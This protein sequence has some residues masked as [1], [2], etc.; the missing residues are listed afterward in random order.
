MDA[1][2]VMKIIPPETETIRG[3]GNNQVEFAAAA[4]VRRKW[5]PY[6]THTIA[7]VM[8]VGSLRV[9]Y[10][11]RSRIP[12]Q[13]PNTRSVPMPPVNSHMVLIKPT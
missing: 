13:V 7:T 10:S 6:R 4:K 3:K 5:I 2:T 9:R 11:A 1:P 12:H 8:K